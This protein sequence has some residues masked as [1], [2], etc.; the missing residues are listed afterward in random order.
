MKKIIISFVSVLLL[1]LIGFGVYNLTMLYSSRPII[2]KTEAKEE[3]ESDSSEGADLSKEDENKTLELE[4]NGTIYDL[5]IEDN[6]YDLMHKMANTKIEAEDGQIW[7]KV[8]IT[9][10][11]VNALI[12]AV[13][14][15]SY[16][17]KEEIL[18]ILNRWKAKDF[19]NCVDEHN[20]FWKKLGGSIGKATGLKDE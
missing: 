6:L 16:E 7:G 2:A 9:D 17:D 4:V 20:Y 12:E 1:A 3:T 15:A 19:S 14:T 5:S 13:S 11:A 10:G 8:E 18:Q